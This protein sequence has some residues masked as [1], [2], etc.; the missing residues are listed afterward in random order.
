MAKFIKKR[1]PK[2]GLLPGSLLHIGEKKTHEIKLTISS[3]NETFYEEK[4]LKSVDEYVSFFRDLSLRV[5]K[6]FISWVN[7]DGVHDPSVVKTLSDIFGVH[8][9][10]QEDILNTDQRPKIEDYGNYLYLVLKML[11]LNRNKRNGIQIE[12]VSLIIFQNVV[13]S[14]QEEK[15]GDVFDSIRDRIKNS[16]GLIRKEGADYLA[17]SLID[18]IVDNYFII[19]EN[20]E[21]QIESVEKIFLSNHANHTF[22]HIHHLK[23]EMIILRKAVWPLRDVLSALGRE[24]SSLIRPTTQ[25]YLRDVYDHAIQVIE[26]IETFRDVVSEMLEV[27]L[28]TLSH[29]MNSIVKILTMITT[30]FMPLSFIAGV[31]GMNFKH[32]P[33]LGWKWGYPLV[34]GVMVAATICMVFYFKKK[35]WV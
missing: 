6:P 9:L 10:I 17:Y 33:E 16:K 4:E 11:S 32:M 19:L 29:K 24:G 28:S 5:E 7:V 8:P 27:H 26:V 3:Y 21:E 13:V 30:V 1:S 22:E 35:K 25:M 23:K 20:I 14:F 34:L 12:Q 2:A 18:T 31:Y 15:I